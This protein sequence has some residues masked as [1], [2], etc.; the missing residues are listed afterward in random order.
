[1]DNFSSRTI[2]FFASDPKRPNDIKLAMMS[3]SVSLTAKP[4]L[5]PALLENVVLC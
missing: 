2:W 3:C 1:M 5:A 4:I